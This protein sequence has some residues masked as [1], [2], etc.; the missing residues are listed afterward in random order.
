MRLVVCII[1]W[2]SLY[3]GN[4]TYASDVYTNIWA[5]EVPG[6]LE[7]AKSM[8]MKHGFTYE[9]HVRKHGFA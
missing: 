7:E 5:V 2:I 9:K 6:S 1:L 8:A 3:I 4:A